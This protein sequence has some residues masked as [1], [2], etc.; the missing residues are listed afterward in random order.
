MLGALLGLFNLGKVAIF[1]Q[2]TLATAFATII[3]VAEQKPLARL[4][5][6]DEFHPLHPLTLV[7]LRL[8]AI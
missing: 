1:E 6:I 2:V 4:L 7:H 3:F 5:A 8:V